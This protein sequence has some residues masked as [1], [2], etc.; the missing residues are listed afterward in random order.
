MFVFVLV[1]ISVSIA[2]AVTISITISV[3]IAI[4]VT[5]S[6]VALRLG[7][8]V[9]DHYVHLVELAFLVE[10]LEV[11]QEATVFGSY[12]DNVEGDIGYAVND[13]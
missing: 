13:A 9:V 3:S 11:R 8:A 12:A 10:L 5:I 2:I 7:I 6:V 4:A 1:A